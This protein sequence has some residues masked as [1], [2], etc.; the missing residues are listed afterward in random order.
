M[1]TEFLPRDPQP[2]W[3]HCAGLIVLLHASESLTPAAARVAM[4][5]ARTVQA[6]AAQGPA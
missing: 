2:S 6:R 3:N 1:H 4:A 5:F